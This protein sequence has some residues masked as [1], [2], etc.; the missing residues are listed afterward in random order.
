[1]M[2][3]RAAPAPA[4]LVPALDLLARG[5]WLLPLQGKVP[6][7]AYA[8]RGW[9]SATND[10]ERVRGWLAKQAWLNLGI[11]T[12]PSDIVVV[13]L[14]E[15][16]DKNGVA[17]IREVV[18]LAGAGFVVRTGSGWH[19]YYLQPDPPIPHRKGLLA[20]VDIISRGYCVAPGSIHP[21][22]G[23]QYV[24]RRDHLAVMPG[25]VAEAL[26]SAIA[27][28]ISHAC[29]ASSDRPRGAA[30][31][32]GAGIIGRFNAAHDPVSILIAHGY[33]FRGKKLICPDSDSGQA[34][35]EVIE[36]GARIVSHHGSDP[37][38]DERPKDAFD[39]YRI[40]EHG[41]DYRRAVK[42]AA[43]LLRGSH[44]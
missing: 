18:D 29:V 12:E 7:A 9:H 4:I 8:P 25:D 11:A 15:R 27:D 17:S 41:G 37:L 32:G 31:T 44:G 2:D 26:R 38:G 6:Y 21:D 42:A 24:L 30:R 39:I 22:T 13:D 23:R 14:D 40:L 34:G 43:D 28:R 20:G 5:F 10:P 19:V 33:R 35:V 36:D 3:Q 16:D 1:M